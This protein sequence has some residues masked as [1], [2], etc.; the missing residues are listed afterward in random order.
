MGRWLFVGGLLSLVG[1]GAAPRCLEAATDERL[2]P[3]CI[4][5]DRGE[6]SVEQEYLPGVVH[7]ELGGSDEGAALEAQAIAAR[8]YLLGYLVRRGEEARVPIGSRFQCW[9]AGAKGAAR[10]AAHYTADIVMTYGGDPITANY[11]AGARSLAPD[12]TPLSPEDNGYDHD[13]WGAMRQLYL[14]ARRRRARRPFGGTAWTEVVVTRNE[15]RRA[16]EVKPTPMAGKH[17]ANRGALGQRAA[18]CL[19]ENLGYEVLDVLRY[20]YGED[21]VLSHPLPG[22]EPTVGLGPESG[23]RIGGE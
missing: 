11:V 15:G 13:S 6:M 21:V 2:L 23:E 19:A 8:T 10:D 22:L 20:F 3:A 17:A 12:C 1:C 5:T 7:C 18:I 4:D 14:D 9:K 16:A